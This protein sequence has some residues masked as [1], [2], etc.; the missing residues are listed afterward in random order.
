M[1]LGIS[2][3]R[4]DGPASQLRAR[5]RIGGK[6]VTWSTGTA[7][8]SEALQ[9]AA[10]EF[11]RRSRSG[12]PMPEL[13]SRS[14]PEPVDGP[15]PPPSLPALSSLESPAAGGGAGSRRLLSEALASAF[16]GTATIEPPK[17]DDAPAAS[18]P[19][20]GG[21]AAAD[22]P[23]PAARHTYA[24]VAKVAVYMIEAG[25]QR[26]VRYCGREPEEM[27][28]NERAMITEGA[29]EELGRIFGRSELGP[30]GKIFL[31]AA[32]AGF[33]MWSA[34]TPIVKPVAA[35]AKL[36]SVPPP[37]PADERDPLPPPE[38]SRA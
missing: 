22:P 23:S 24:V 25:L 31:G 1:A 37:P 3:F 20:G 32:C 38:K 13:T 16:A 26:A 14:S 35:P 11:Q 5:A 33:G 2:L 15:A 8:E 4:S 34:G 17:P 19:P 18:A 36:R 7:D 29:E 12:N 9:R 6:L 27:D 30:K 10:A 21:P 28:D